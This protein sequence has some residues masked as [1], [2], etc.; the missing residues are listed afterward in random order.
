MAEA[1]EKGL[2]EN[3]VGWARRNILVPVPDV[4]DFAELN[5][6]ILE[7]CQR[8]F[9]HTIRGRDASV[10]EL[11]QLER[12]KL[13]PLPRLAF[14]PA[15]LLPKGQLSCARL[16]VFPSTSIRRNVPW[17]A[18]ARGSLPH[19]DLEGSATR[20]GLEAFLAPGWPQTV[21]PHGRIPQI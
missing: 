6:R 2:V 15:S 4:K 20:I 12:R 14:D 9:E 16:S 3:L 10:G 13:L 7:R 11:L 17:L 19:S 21:D 1:H 5:A 8:Y 18:S